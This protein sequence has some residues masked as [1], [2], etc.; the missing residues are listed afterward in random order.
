M[1]YQRWYTKGDIGGAVGRVRRYGTDARCSVAGCEESPKTNGL[2][3]KHR[4]R[5]SRYRDYG[6]PGRLPPGPKDRRRT[7][8]SA[9][10]VG[11]LWFWPHAEISK[12]FKVLLV[13]E[14]ADP[15]WFVLEDVLT[16]Q[17]RKVPPKHLRL[18]YKPLEYD[19]EGNLVCK[20]RWAWLSCVKSSLDTRQTQEHP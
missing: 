9:F 4:L 16:G 14:Y 10:A 1:H 6:P 17:V 8:A 12:V 20:T 11:A 18:A 2:C 7:I 15:P 3:N 13:S 19:A 5:L